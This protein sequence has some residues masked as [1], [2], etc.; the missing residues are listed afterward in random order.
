MT[1]LVVG[2]G[3]LGGLYA[4]AL[5][6]VGEV[7]ALDASQ[8]HVAAIN[9]GG[10]R[11]RGLEE[12]TAP[13]RATADPASLAGERF[14]LVIVAV[15]STATRA[16][17][18]AVASYLKGAP[19]LS[20]Q[21]G[22]GNEEIIREEVEGPVLQGVSLLAALLTG[23]GEVKK[24]L[25]GLTYIGPFMS[26]SGLQATR[27]Q[28]DEAGAL[29]RAAGMEVEVRDD[30]RDVVWTKLIMNS[31]IMPM[32]MLT[33]LDSVGLVSVAPV[34]ALIEEMATEGTAVMAK[35]GLRPVFDPLYVLQRAAKERT[36]PHAGSMSRD[37]AAG[38]QTEID[39]LTGAMVAAGERLGVPMPKSKAFYQI[40]KGF[41]ASFLKG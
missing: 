4:A 18:R 1:V 31:T 24:N 3:S 34:R 22:L 30:I 25:D 32:R 27:A 21:N 16:A 15:K 28:A 40:F 39:F 8:E 11:L 35:M 41:E 36:S 9:A 20:I 29:L 10:L 5:T 33:R 14:E 37:V 12:M 23:P 6:R 2:C 26:D 13:V 19:V 38:V 7:W 17:V